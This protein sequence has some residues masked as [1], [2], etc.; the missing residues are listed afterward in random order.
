MEGLDDKE[1]GTSEAEDAPELS[2]EPTTLIKEVIPSK[3]EETSHESHQPE[4]TEKKDYLQLID[5]TEE[6]KG[7]TKDVAPPEITGTD[8]VSPVRAYMVILDV[9]E[10]LAEKLY[11]SGYR[12]LGEL[13]EAIPEDLVYVEGINPT[14]ARKIYAKLH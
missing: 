8:S 12:N 4:D 13:K 3:K 1:T 5:E 11:S 6:E 7:E 2:D 10:E 14:L 9:E